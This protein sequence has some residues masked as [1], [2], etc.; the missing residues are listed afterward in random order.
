MHEGL[1][2]NIYQSDNMKISA[3]LKKEEEI[4][5]HDYEAGLLFENG[6]FKEILGKGKYTI[7]KKD[8]EKE[9]FVIDK[10]IKSIVI[11]GQE[12]LTKD[13]MNLRLNILAKYKVDDPF[14]AINEV[15]DYNNSVYQEIQMAVRGIVGGKE[16][17]ELVSMKNL[18]DENNI[19]EIQEMCEKYG[20]KIESIELKDIILPGNLKGILLKEIEAKK[21]SEIALIKARS[22]VASTRALINAAN[23]IKE[24]PEIIELK[25]MESME[26]V[27]DNGNVILFPLPSNIFERFKNKTS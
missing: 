17:D 11:T 15:E 23:L 21:E 4:V 14:K 27:S 10:R 5:I 12:I 1:E 6:A 8:F 2:D 25:M 3:L 13:K 19:K 24:H 16:L 18:F 26:K 7:S 22:E 20:V 9:I